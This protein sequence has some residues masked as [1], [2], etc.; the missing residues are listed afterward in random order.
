MVRS[1]RFSE[2]ERRVRA[3]RDRPSGVRGGSEIN[4]GRDR[5]RARKA[6]RFAHSY[7][8]LLLGKV[9][10]DTYPSSTMLDII[11]KL[12]TPETAPAYAAVLMSKIDGDTYP[13]MS[14][15]RRVLA[16]S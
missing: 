12:I 13:S 3:H 8:E 14:I 5:W 2:T 10:E 16:L 11:E 6:N 1:G 4:Q 7:F 15:I 9:D